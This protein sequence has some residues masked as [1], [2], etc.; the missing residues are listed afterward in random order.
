M[1]ILA[2]VPLVAFA[3][4]NLQARTEGGHRSVFSAEVTYADGTKRKETISNMSIGGTAFVLIGKDPQGAEHQV[5]LDTIAD[6]D[7]IAPEKIRVTYKDGKSTTLTQDGPY[8]IQI[9]SPQGGTAE[10][11]FENVRHVHFL[12]PVRRDSLGNAIFDGWPFSPYTGK[13]IP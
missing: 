8:A 7:V 9:A 12:R 4:Q 10:A 13:R 11:R 2:L 5:W 6:L 1:P 3:G